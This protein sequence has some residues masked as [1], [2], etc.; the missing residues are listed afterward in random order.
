MGMS[1][2]EAVKMQQNMLLAQK[3]GLDM[4]AFV[5]GKIGV[6]ELKK[7]AQTLKGEERARFDAMIRQK[8]ATSINEEFNE[9]LLD[10]KEA[11]LP[12]M[13]PLAS[14]LKKISRMVKFF[15][16]IIY[17]YFHTLF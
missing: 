8:E 7:A 9:A 10:L 16:Q 4:Q 14:F 11:L 2:D 3:A 5:E 12:L 17:I 1:K 13:K 6:S 15:T